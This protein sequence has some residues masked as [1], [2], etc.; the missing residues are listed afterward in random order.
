MQPFFIRGDF[1]YD[2]LNDLVVLLQNNK[3]ETKIAFIDYGKTTKVHILGNE[4]DPFNMTDYSWIGVFEKVKN[5]EALW[6]N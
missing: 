6:S 5:K 4:D 3:N 2:N 1:F